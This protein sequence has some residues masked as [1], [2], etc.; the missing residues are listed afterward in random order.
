MNKAYPKG[1][2]FFVSRISTEGERRGRRGKKKRSEKEK[3]RTRN[4]DVC[5][6]IDP[7]RVATK[8]ET[9]LI[10]ATAL[11]VWWLLSLRGG[12]GRF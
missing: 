8:G 10:V 3:S 12:G 5:D 4:Y 2:A 7:Q 6:V 11:Q 1:Y 9:A